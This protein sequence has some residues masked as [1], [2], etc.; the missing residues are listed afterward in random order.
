MP[1]PTS[2]SPPE[3]ALTNHNKTMPLALVERLLRR[4]VEGQFEQALSILTAAPAF[5]GP[6]QSAVDPV[7]RPG[8][9]TVPYS[10]VPHLRQPRSALIL[11]DRC[12][13]ATFGS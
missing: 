13:N 6:H 2:R 9:T 5:Q 4:Q 7:L 11:V 12:V 3:F 8:W 10:W 1:V